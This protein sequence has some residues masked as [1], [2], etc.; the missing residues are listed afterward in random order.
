MKIELEQQKLVL[1]TKNKQMEMELRDLRIDKAGEGDTEDY[2]GH[3]VAHY[4]GAAK[5]PKMPYFD[6]NIDSMDS[7]LNRFEKV[8]DAQGWR[9]ENYAICLS[10]LLKGKALD[11]YSRLSPDQASDYGYLKEALLKC[12]QLTEDG[13]RESLDRPGQK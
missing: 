6:E 8:A 3:S 10:A 2:L 4:H 5:M 13:L 12:Y 9:K 7:Y 11:V 1:E